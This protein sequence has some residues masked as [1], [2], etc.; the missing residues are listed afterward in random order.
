M[1]IG[2]AEIVVVVVAV[3]VIMG[4]SVMVVVLLAQQEGAD[5]ID[6]EPEHGDRD[7]F[8]PGDRNRIDQPRKTLEGDLDRDNAED[9]GAGKGGEIAELSGAEG[10]MR[11]ARL[12]PCKQIG[13]RR[14]AKRRGM[15]YVMWTLLA[16]FI[17]DAIGIILYF[18]LR[19]PLPKPCTGCGAA[20][21]P[22]FTYCPK[23]GTEVRPACS[24]CGKA[25]EPDWLNCAYC[26]KKIAVAPTEQV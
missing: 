13:Q 2:G 25:I 1:D 3:S 24:S 14:D 4:V 10:E 23:C 15:R 21:K 11:V 5:E 7:R 18:I 12:S 22:G 19:D 8:A 26:G 20:V 17:P 9:D 6:D 16:I